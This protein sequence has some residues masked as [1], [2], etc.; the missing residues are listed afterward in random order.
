VAGTPPAIVARL[1]AETANVLRLP[2]VRERPATLGA[3]P[4]GSTQ[5][6]L[7]AF[8]RAEDARWGRIIRENGIRSE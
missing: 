3:E 4:V 6:E 7:A 1:Q 8:M 2:E 5:E